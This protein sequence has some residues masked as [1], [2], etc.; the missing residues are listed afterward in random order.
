MLGRPMD[1]QVA[2]AHADLRMADLVE[3]HLVDLANTETRLDLDIARAGP[4]ACLW[5]NR[6]PFYPVSARCVAAR[7]A[8]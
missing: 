2:S 4:Q 8:R 3:D 1:V 5:T 7:A 6:P